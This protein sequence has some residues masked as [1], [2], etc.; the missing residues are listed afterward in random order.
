[1]NPKPI[2]PDQS[3]RRFYSE[4]VTTNSRPGNWVEDDRKISARALYS[5]QAA[6]PR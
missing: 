2:V 1:M 3:A 5:F 6:S 4:N